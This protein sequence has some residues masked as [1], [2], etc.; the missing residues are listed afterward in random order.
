[1]CVVRAMVQ[2]IK[3]AVNHL[4]TGTEEK[5]LQEAKKRRKHGG[6]RISWEEVTLIFL[7]LTERIKE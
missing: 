2:I 6:Q 3:S 1:M 5:E 4:R 7:R